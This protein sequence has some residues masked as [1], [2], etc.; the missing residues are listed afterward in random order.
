[1]EWRLKY[2]EFEIPKV[3]EEKIEQFY[4][5]NIRF[6]YSAMPM[7][8]RN[9]FN[10]SNQKTTVVAFVPKNYKPV[11]YDEEDDY[12]E[13]EEYEENENPTPTGDP[14]DSKFWLVMAKSE[15]VD[16]SWLIIQCERF[17]QGKDLAMTPDQIASEIVESVKKNANNDDQLANS[18]LDLLQYDMDFIQLLISKK[19]EIIAASLTG[20][21]KK[22]KKGPK[23]QSKQSGAKQNNYYD[24]RQGRKSVPK[25]ITANGVEV[26][27]GIQASS[28]LAIPL[29]TIQV[30]HDD[31]EAFIIPA[32]RP[33]LLPLNER[34]PVTTVDEFARE[35][36]S[37]K[38]SH[39]NH[40]QSVIFD[41]AYNKGENLLLCAPTGA[42]K[43]DV[44]LM[45]IVHE[46]KQHYYYGVIDRS[47]F[48]IVYVAP[49]KALAQEIVENLS[50]RL[51]PLK[52]VVREYTGDM[53]LTK[54][55]LSETQI[56]VSTPE[57][58]D[59]TTRKSGDIA[60]VQLVKLLILD[61]VH[62]LNE[63]RG[64]VIETL[65]ARTLRLQ[66]R[67][68]SLVRIVGLSATLPNYIDVSTFL[69]VNPSTGL[70]SF[71]GSYRPLPLTQEFLA[72]P[73][74]RNVAVQKEQLA[75]VCYER[76]LK[77]IDQGHQVMIFVHSRKDTLKTAY[78]MRDFSTADGMSN[79]FQGDLDIK[80]TE[81]A[82]L[83][84]LREIL[85]LGFGVHHAGMIRS[86]R[87]LVETFFRRKQIRVLICTATLAWG[88][89]LP[90]HTVIIK[91]TQ[92]YDAKQ[93][94][95]VDVG[96][97]DI[98]QIFGRAGRPG[99][100]VSGEGI[101]IAPR[102]KI[103][104]Y[105]K[106]VGQQMPIESQ[107]TSRL[108]DNL[109]AEISLGTVS[110]VNEAIVWLSYTYLFV[111]MQRNPS[112]YGISQ[113]DF[114]IND[115]NLVFH[116]TALVRAAADVLDQSKMIR[117]NRETG[118]LSIT[119]LGR[120]ASNFYIEYETIQ[121]FNKLMKDNMTDADI[122]CMVSQ[123]NEFKNIIVR[124]DEV[125]ELE[126]L[127]KEY[128]HIRVFGGI[129]NSYG[130]V[131]IL[132]QS[133]ISKAELENFAL[134]SDTAYINQNASRLFRCLFEIAVWKG[135][136]G[137]AD[138]VLKFCKM[139]DKRMWHFQ[140]PL[141]QFGLKQ[142][143]MRYLENVSVDTLFDM[144]T[145]EI[146]ALV[147]HNATGQTIK[148]FIRKIPYL[149]MEAT[150]QP[151][152]RTILKVKL[153]INAD[154]KWDD[155]LHGSVEPFWIWMED[156]I[157]IY[158]SEYFLLHRDKRRETHEINF[159]VPL[160]EPI[161]PQ[162]VIRAISDRW[163][164]AESFYTVSFNKLILPDLYPPH[165]E[166]L[167]LDPLPKSALKNSEYEK[168]FY[169]SHFNSI[170]T[171][172]YHT[173][174]HTDEN[175]LLGAPTGSGKTVAA[176]LAILRVFNEY[177]GTKIVYIGPLK[178]LV[179]ERMK[180]WRNK[181][182]TKLGRKVIELTGDVTPD[183]KELLSADI[184]LTTPEKW[185]GV[186]R[187][188]QT[189]GYVQQVSLVIIDEIH[190]LGEERGPILEVIVTRMRYISSKVDTV[191][192]IVGLSTALANAIDLAKWLGIERNGLYNFKPAIR[193]VPLQAHIA[194]YPGIHYCPRMATMNKP[195]YQ[196]IRNHS[197]DK[198]TLVFVSSRR[199][200]R[201]TALELISLCSN[202][203]IT[204]NKMSGAETELVIDKAK[205]ANLKHTLHYGIGVHHA[206]L[207]ESDRA[208]VEELFISTK[209]QVLICTSTLAWGVNLPA[210]LVVIKGTE[211]YDAKS[212]RYQDF[213]ITDVLQMMGRA[214]RPQYDQEGVAVIL[215]HEPKKNFYRRFLYEPFPVES[216]LH[217]YL[218]DHINAEITTGMIKS[219]QDAID[220]VTWT[221]FYRR[222][223]INP[224]Y[225]GLESL[226][227]ADVNLFLSEIIEKTLKELEESSCISIDDTAIEPLTLGHIASFYY[228]S[229]KTVS[230]FSDE[231]GEDCTIL[232]L[233][234]TLCSAQEYEELPVRHNEEFTNEELSQKIRYKVDATTYDNPHTK[235][236][237]LLQAHLSHI[238]MPIHDYVT[239][240]K[241]VL[242]QAVRIIQ[243]IVDVAAD[244]GWLSSTINSIRLLQMVIQAKWYESS[245]LLTLPH[246]TEDLVNDLKAKV[247]FFFIEY[248][249]GY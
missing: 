119:F 38:Y 16:D 20:G 29:G 74:G 80:E 181:F 168:L 114:Y 186:S 241:S 156:G 171:Q 125:M 233:L 174:M 31:H 195:T 102:E 89:N 142:I 190:M 42:G 46:I 24:K 208:L 30:K 49:M 45:T 96:M 153:T 47:S 3:T 247:I 234:Q 129:E 83:R 112:A 130:K 60:F 212:K 146:T 104:K 205:D 163:L 229:Y 41:A 82:R 72:L 113:G 232:E 33:K 21:K 37:M 249:F 69:K 173:I 143:V 19:D 18:L 155:R 40:I 213:P 137:F 138:E 28:S 75:R 187:S 243:A 178:A 15:E 84:E 216:S 180:D 78:E 240:T 58:W 67:T 123:A 54:K 124:E 172:V 1:M 12:E 5:K 63:D 150:V 203:E 188:W 246:F 242:D 44:A 193:P 162:Y 184:V 110:N 220:Y 127:M 248:L 134:I 175:V 169:F 91:G 225:Y 105:L 139:L 81:K 214:G 95:F 151:I 170:Q 7:Y 132:L 36:F 136:S 85:P 65:V 22:G 202:D 121:L 11:S 217:K 221:Y 238:P 144:G 101:M 199:Q 107:F 97:L 204:F 222:L 167:P 228:L 196:A 86:D 176:E 120:V 182:V 179:K 158:H 53:T 14:T 88:V 215:V 51:K 76:A 135:H 66:E 87:N 4:G 197:P 237:I 13:Y 50:K 55:E 61:E 62:L 157:T 224:S 141:H 56:I 94:K 59:V 219:K 116:R 106:L 218:H 9:M 154:F 230:R 185:D 117:F 166:L 73:G 92:I 145:D 183:I 194:G 200:T 244:G 206:G 43:T 52:I 8:K 211:F 98:M 140:H 34:V 160:P 236:F 26:P 148:Q 189:R 39:F 103:D 223:L 149:E 118:E 111:R 64:P 133:Y 164:E 159:T 128:C 10:S 77:S 68:Q 100:D 191:C 23:F 152:T 115:P 48:K 227:V 165:T 226:E 177:P 27:V 231:I 239:D 57:K 25:I 71:D 201:L 32:K 198:P 109:N 131:N 108:E 17:S 192:R 147:R 235:A 207:A 90:A 245:P 35:V 209:I 70:F 93:G 126:K 6:A 210:H 99:L 122:L 161:P 2:G 79:L